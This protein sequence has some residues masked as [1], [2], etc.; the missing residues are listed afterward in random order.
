MKH[1]AAALILTVF[2]NGCCHC[3][4]PDPIDGPT[5]QAK[6]DLEAAQSLYPDLK[7]KWTGI[8]Q[9]LDNRL[10][11][12]GAEKFPKA[13]RAAGVK[14][15]PKLPAD[16][17]PLDGPRFPAKF[18]WVENGTGP[19]LNQKD[20]RFCW[21]FAIITALETEMN[22]RNDLKKP[23]RLSA[24]QLID[25]TTCGD[26]N[27]GYYSCVLEFLRQNP[28]TTIDSDSYA[29][30]ETKGTCRA[31]GQGIA[32]FRWWVPNPMG[33]TN[34]GILKSYLSEVAWGRAPVIV[35]VRI[36]SAQENPKANTHWQRY[37]GEDVLNEVPNYR[38]L[39][40]NH[41]LVLVG[42][43]DTKKAWL[44]KNSWGDQWGYHGYG[45]VGYGCFNLDSDP[46]CSQIH[47]GLT[48]KGYK[49]YVATKQ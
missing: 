8:D 17:D 47:A 7:L 11:T 24:Q 12:I 23:I 48:Q 43:D 19:I 21:A 4:K 32:E 10:K 38:T 37:S 26:A 27:G 15:A 46:F 20:K 39:E 36:P 40:A 3:K 41:V 25:C 6:A 42:W 1:F 13:A 16:D 29:Y 35:R 18:S 28:A 34:R 14:N 49:E 9:P 45:W 30:T 33:G 44:V 2:L 22:N 31:S 5:P